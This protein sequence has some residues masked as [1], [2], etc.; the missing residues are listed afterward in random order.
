M[1]HRYKS[2]QYGI[3]GLVQH[4]AMRKC[5]RQVLNILI[6]VLIDNKNKFI[7]VL[8]YHAKKFVYLALRTVNRSTGPWLVVHHVMSLLNT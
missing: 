8:Y 1:C 5:C 2:D 3:G 4:L 7:T 6:D